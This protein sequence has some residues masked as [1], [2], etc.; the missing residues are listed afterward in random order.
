VM[1]VLGPFVI[2]S[3]ICFIIFMLGFHNF[4]TNNEEN[5]CEMTY[6]FEYPQFV[7]SFGNLHKLISRADSLHVLISEVK[8][9]H[10]FMLSVCK[11]T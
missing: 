7:V 1:A 9:V 10:K 6:M 3:G 2:F 4:L 5:G 11:V 8:L